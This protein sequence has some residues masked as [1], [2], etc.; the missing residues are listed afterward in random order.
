MLHIQGTTEQFAS[1]EVNDILVHTNEDGRFLVRLKN[2]PKGKFVIS[3]RVV[4]KKG[5]SA[6]FQQE[7]PVGIGS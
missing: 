1:I 2:V 5:T 6:T 4:T 3:F 7:I